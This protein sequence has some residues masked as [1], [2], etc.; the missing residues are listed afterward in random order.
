MRRSWSDLCSFLISLYTSRNKI[1]ERNSRKL[2]KSA[3]SVTP[4]DCEPIKDKRCP[5]LR[6]SN[7]SPLPCYHCANRM[8]HLRAMA[9]Q[10]ADLKMAGEANERFKNQ[11]LK[12]V[13]ALCGSSF[14]TQIILTWL[15]G[16]AWR[17]KFRFAKIQTQAEYGR[18]FSH[19]HIHNE[20]PRIN[21]SIMDC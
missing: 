15:L 14:R 18:T 1:R 19:M 21:W 16:V 5:S 8:A 10:L 7:E 20:L 2:A 11:C 6:L 4:S 17:T 9:K 12:I 13:T 3:R